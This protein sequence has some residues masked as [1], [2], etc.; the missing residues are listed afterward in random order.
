[1]VKKQIMV[2]IKADYPDWA[3]IKVRTNL[4]STV[5]RCIKLL[6]LLLSV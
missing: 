4:H 2:V 5:S 3:G 6:I 1:M